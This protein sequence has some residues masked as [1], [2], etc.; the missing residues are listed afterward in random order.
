LPLLSM[1]PTAI[2]VPPISTPA[3]ND[4]LLFRARRLL[5]LF[6]NFTLII[7]PSSMDVHEQLHPNPAA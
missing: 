3:I 5:L 4:I 7:A 6:E 2:L 1:T